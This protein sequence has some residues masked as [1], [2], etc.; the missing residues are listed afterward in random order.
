MKVAGAHAHGNRGKF[1][2]SVALSD[3]LG[4]PSREGPRRNHKCDHT[5]ENV[6]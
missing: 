1:P 2:A 4:Y 3:N 5:K 6:L